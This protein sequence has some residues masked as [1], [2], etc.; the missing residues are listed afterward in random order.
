V[1]RAGPPADAATRRR[2]LALMGIEVYALRPARAHVAAAAEAAAVPAPAAPAERLVL[3]AGGSG[4][5]VRAER[6]V[7]HLLLALG[8]TPDEVVVAERARPDLPALCLGGAPGD[9]DAVL[10]PPL[11]ALRRS[12]AA[13]RALWRDLRRLKRRLG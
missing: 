2:A 12:P 1:S 6:L 4:V 9:A 11:D 8:L 3:V 10:A 7:R 5:D 13:K